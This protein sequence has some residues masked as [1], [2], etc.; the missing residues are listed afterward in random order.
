M[1]FPVFP[2]FRDGDVLR[3]DGLMAI[4]RYARD[5]T[6]W[7]IARDPVLLPP[8]GRDEA[9]NVVD[10]AQ[11][12]I[13]N[14]RARTA[15]GQV[16][17]RDRVTLERTGPRWLVPGLGEDDLQQAGAMTWTASPQPEAIAR[18]AEDGRSFSWLIP[19]STINSSENLWQECQILAKRLRQTFASLVE[20]ALSEAEDPSWQLG[21]LGDAA[22][23]THLL[24]QDPETPARLLDSSLAQTVQEA[25]AAVIRRF[26]LQNTGTDRFAKFANQ[27]NQLGLLLLLTAAEKMDEVAAHRQRIDPDELLADISDVFGSATCSLNNAVKLRKLLAEDGPLAAGLAYANR[28]TGPERTQPKDVPDDLVVYEFRLPPAQVNE[29]RYLELPD[30]LRLITTFRWGTSGAFTAKVLQ[31]DRVAGNVRFK[32]DRPK[33]ETCL[34]VRFHGYISDGEAMKKVRLT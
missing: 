21:S 29:D 24:I 11:S 13:R 9:V 20:K 10:L 16:I 15:D 34:H 7:A 31:E 2:A 25:R 14:L 23:R 12:C 1:E 6:R 28:I 26:I 30:R 27:L 33:E 4:G 8:T 3:A 18:I 32:L 22:A 19:A 5:L 17:I